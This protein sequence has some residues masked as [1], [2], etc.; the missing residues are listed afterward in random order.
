MKIAIPIHGDR[1]MPRFGC[2][3]EFMVATVED[4]TM[5]ATERLPA[6]A[7]NIG[8][9]LEAEGVSVLIC[10]GIHQRFQQLIQERNIEIIWGVMGYWQ[11]VLQAYLNGTLQYDWTLC[12]RRR[13]REGCHFRWGY[14]GGEN[15]AR[16]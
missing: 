7:Q 10:G 13:G 6:T 11:D 1:V 14:Q 12:V 3:R 5:L 8:P 2:T 16:I 15:N 9:V 4:G